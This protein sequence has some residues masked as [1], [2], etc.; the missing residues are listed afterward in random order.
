MNTFS[1][2]SHGH[3][4]LV[5]A[6]ALS[7]L[8]SSGATSAASGGGSHRHDQCQGVNAAPHG[9]PPI[10]VTIGANWT[11]TTPTGGPATVAPTLEQVHVA[12][13]EINGSCGL[14]I[15]TS[16]HSSKP[17]GA[18]L[19]V[20]VRDNATIAAQS[21]TVTNELIDRGA[22]AVVGGGGSVTGPPAAQ[23]A[24]M[25]NIP[26]GA[27]QAAADAISGCTAAELANPAVTKSAVPV[28]GPLQ[29]FNH[30]GLAFRT[31]ATGYQW[32][33]VAATYAHNTYPGLTKAAIAFL[34]NDFG[35]PNRDGLRASFPGTVVAEAGFSGAGPTPTVADFKT[36]LRVITSDD[37][38]LILGSNTIALLG[39]FMQAYAELRADSTWVDKPSNFDTLRF[40][41]GSTLSGDYSGLN[42][43][44]RAALVEQSVI[45]QPSWD[46]ESPAFQR[47]FRV[48]QAYNPAALPPSSGFTMSAYDALIVMSLAIS[49]A[50]T[51]SA[52]AVSAKV[53][54]VSNPPGKVVCPGQW[55]K[56][57]RLLTKGKD[58]NYEGAL[59]SVDIDERG[60]AT[61]IT[62]GAFNVQPDGSTLLSNTFG[63]PPPP[64]CRGRG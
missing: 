55:R 22:A 45:V 8:A 47:W 20:E 10:P 51:T 28:Y 41:W 13:S 23:A 59:G 27:N 7:A 49:A 44:A 21:A 30:R 4:P 64:R 33:T 35:R 2:V 11:L 40:V 53:R 19:V 14:R 62:Y 25:R 6:V 46:P 32:G 5:I 3:A 56:A 63:S 15:A 42:A 54:E 58:I 31:T 36:L 37:P 52:R 61:G 39:P 50:G 12:T 1:P 60:N 38:Q 48:Y 26:F 43:A 34:D 57:F 9:R 16:K 24:V 29:C 18:R 17:A